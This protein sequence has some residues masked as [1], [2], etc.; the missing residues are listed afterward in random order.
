MIPE[1]KILSFIHSH[2]SSTPLIPTNYPTWVYEYMLDVNVSTQQH[3]YKF[4]ESAHMTVGQKLWFAVKK[5]VKN[6]ICGCMGSAG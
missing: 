4:Q 3:A 5:K 1:M 6:T 2:G